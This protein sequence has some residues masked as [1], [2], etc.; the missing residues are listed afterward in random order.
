MTISLDRGGNG[1]EG[2]TVTLLHGAGMDHTVWRFQIRRLAGRR[3]RVLAPDLPG[4]GTSRDEPRSSVE[5]WGEWLVEFLTERQAA[6]PVV[7]H[8]LGGLI[9]LRAAACCPDVVPRLV[10]VGTGVPMPVHPA[11]MAAAHDDLPRAASFI[12]GWS[13]PPRHPGGHLEAGTWERGAIVRLVE[14]SGPGVLAKDLA[15]T[16]SYHPGEDLGRV[17]ADSL[18]VRGDADRMVAER[19]V[20]ALVERIA[21]AR[22]VV[23]AGAGHQPMIQQ[24]RLFSRLLDEFLVGDGKS[25]SRYPVR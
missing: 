22:M 5:E 15:A 20:R 23:L 19:S 10:L 14:R 17:R 4:H 24:P 12:A 2:Q 25:S 8:S 1:G 21:G 16:A 3:W 13:L 6:G 9:A 18:V 7:G 11:L